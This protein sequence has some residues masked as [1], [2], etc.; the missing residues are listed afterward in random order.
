MALSVHRSAVGSP[1]D[2]SGV[3]VTE[4]YRQQFIKT[5]VVLVPSSFEFS[6]DLSKLLG[7]QAEKKVIDSIEQCGRDIPGIQTICFHGVRVI[8]SSPSIIREID[9]CCFITYQGR[10]YILI[11]EVKCNADIKKRGG[12][13]KKAI[14]QLNTFIE[15]LGNELNVPTDQLQTHAVWPNMDPPEPCSSCQGRHPSLYL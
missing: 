8:G 5:P 6:G 4:Y 12:T 2:S 7:E 14:V 11:T 15:M 3:S 10:R 9:Q 13:R 1:A